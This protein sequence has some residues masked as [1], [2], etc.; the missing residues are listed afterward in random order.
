MI[1][2][3]LSK[4]FAFVNASCNDKLLQRRKYRYLG[5]GL[6]SL[7]LKQFLE[8]YIDPSYDT[9]LVDPDTANIRAMRAYE[10]A[11]FKVVKT[12]KEGTVTWMVRWRI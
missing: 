10:K 8:G 6:A 3:S 7:I 4:D 12:V 5:K 11:G 1:F 2:I 9:C